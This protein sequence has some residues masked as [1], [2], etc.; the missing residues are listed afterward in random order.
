MNQSNI[1]YHHAP[2]GKGFNQ[3]N[4][5]KLKNLC[6]SYVEYDGGK[7]TAFRNELS[8]DQMFFALVRK[9]KAEIPNTHETCSKCSGK[10][11]LHYHRDGGVCYQCDGF[12][13]TKK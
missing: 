3:I 8:D 11:T 12:G 10:G 5:R 4:G 6:K 9:G 2:K 1:I 7:W 13:Y